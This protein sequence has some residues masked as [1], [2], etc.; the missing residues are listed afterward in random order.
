LKIKIN[1]AR[2]IITT[3][4]DSLA[5]GSYE[6]IIKVWSGP[7]GTRRHLFRGVKSQRS[8]HFL[9]DGEYRYGI[10]AE[11]LPQTIN[12]FE[13]SP[14]YNIEKAIRI[15]HEMG[16]RYPTDRNGEAYVMS[17]DFLCWEYDSL[18]HKMVKIARSYK[19]LDSL[20]FATKH[21][22]SVNRTLEKLE[23]ER[24]YYESE[25]IPFELITE[26]HISKNCA[27]NL[28]AHRASALYKAEFIEHEKRF[29]VAFVE[30]CY[31]REHLEITA[32]LEM[33]KPKL[34]LP[35]EDL[36]A[37]YQWG[38]WTHQIPADLEVLIN[39]LRPLKLKEVT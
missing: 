35:Y 25:N 26:A 15:A 14:L 28:K 10:Y 36:F 39:P 24:R 9:S 38:I 33:L 4:L 5:K 7:K 30:S 22:V 32:Q 23:L 17:T 12:Y 2:K 8:H 37:L 6:P 29:M 19:P 20:D 34:M 27:H 31:T 13:Q 18:Q 16:I 1:K 21:P 3:W 11:S